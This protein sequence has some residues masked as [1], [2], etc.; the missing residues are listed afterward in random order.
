M[1][2]DTIAQSS[3]GLKYCMP[4]KPLEAGFDA[5]NMMSLVVGQDQGTIMRAL[6]F[7]FTLVP[8]FIE[9]L[10]WKFLEYFESHNTK[11]LF[12]YYDRSANAYAQAKKDFVTQLKTAIE[13]R[14]GKRTGWTV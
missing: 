7:L 9:Q 3:K 13:T 11:M 2:C 8:E 12:L 5:G 6:K 10:A 4:D 1:F 14:D